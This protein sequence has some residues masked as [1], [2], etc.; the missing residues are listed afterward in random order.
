M[1]GFACWVQQLARSKKLDVAADALHLNAEWCVQLEFIAVLRQHN[2]TRRGWPNVVLRRKAAVNPLGKS[3]RYQ[4]A[5]KYQPT[6]AQGT[7]SP[8]GDLERMPGR[9]SQCV[10]ECC[11]A[12][13]AKEDLP[14]NLLHRF[15]IWLRLGKVDIGKKIIVEICDD[16]VTCFPQHRRPD[17][18]QWLA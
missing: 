4:A 12:V 18:R 8:Q 13:E 5:W 10:V 17:Y 11:V 9:K 14:V 15:R 1:V 3:R 16:A 7:L 2:V 6:V